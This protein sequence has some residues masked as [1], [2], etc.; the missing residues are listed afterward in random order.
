MALLLIRPQH[1]MWR[2]AEHNGT[3]R[4]NTH[5]F[6]TARAACGSSGPTTLSQQT[7]AKAARVA[8]RLTAMTSLIPGSR[9]KGR[10]MM[11]GIDAG[12]ARWPRRS[13]AG[14]SPTG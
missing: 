7:A 3:F 5:A 1:D 9:V 13:A 12:S 11:I 6:V 4:G 8:D 2:P 14:A 10:G